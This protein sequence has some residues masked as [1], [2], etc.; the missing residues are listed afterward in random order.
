MEKTIE[1]VVEQ[2]KAA[3]IK[4]AVDAF[5]MG[6]ELGREAAKSIYK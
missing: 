5:N 6:F 2:W 3:A 1:Q 4:Q